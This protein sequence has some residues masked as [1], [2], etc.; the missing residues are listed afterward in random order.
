MSSEEAVQEVRRI[1]MNNSVEQVHDYLTTITRGIEESDERLKQIVGQSY[2]DL[3]AACDRVVGMERTC[4]KLLALQKQLQLEQPHQQAQKTT[5]SSSPLSTVGGDLLDYSHTPRRMVPT[6]HNEAS[7]RAVPPENSAFPTSTVQKESTVPDLNVLELELRRKLFFQHRCMAIEGLLGA[8]EVQKAAAVLQE[9]RETLRN[10]EN[11]VEQGL[12]LPTTTVDRQQQQQQQL[13]LC[14]SRLYNATG[15]LLRKDADDAALRAVAAAASPADAAGAKHRVRGNSSVD[16]RRSDEHMTDS[17]ESSVTVEHMAEAHAALGILSEVPAPPALLLLI[18]LVSRMIEGDLHLISAVESRRSLGRHATAGDDGARP[19]GVME[20]LRAVLQLPPCLLDSGEAG[21]LPNVTTRRS[22]GEGNKQDSRNNAVIALHAVQRAQQLFFHLVAYVASVAPRLCGPDGGGV[23]ATTVEG[24]NSGG[25][26]LTAE[27]EDEY[28]N[29]QRRRRTVEGLLTLRTRL[30]AQQQEQGEKQL[31]ETTDMTPMRLSGSFTRDALS[32]SLRAVTDDSVDSSLLHADTA[33]DLHGPNR[34]RART[35]YLREVMRHV[36][37]LQLLDPRPLRQ[38]KA[39][40]KYDVDSDC[41]GESNNKD[42]SKDRGGASTTVKYC[43]V[44]ER[45]LMVQELVSR[46][47]GCV[48]EAGLL[49]EP[50]CIGVQEHLARSEASGMQTRLGRNNE[51]LFDEAKW[52]AMVTSTTER[53]LVKA[54]GAALRKADRVCNSILERV[55][56]DAQEE[57]Q[58]PQSSQVED[59][60]RSRPRAP[61]QLTQE[62][63]C[64]SLCVSQRIT[65]LKRGSGNARRYSSPSVPPLKRPPPSVKDGTA[66]NAALARAVVQCVWSHTKPLADG[67]TFYGTM[68]PRAGGSSNSGST[69][70]ASAAPSAATFAANIFAAVLSGGDFSRASERTEEEMGEELLFADDDDEKVEDNNNSTPPPAAAE[71]ATTSAAPASPNPAYVDEGDDAADLSVLRHMLLRIFDAE[72]VQTT[73]QAAA[74]SLITAWITTVLRRVQELMRKREESQRQQLQQLQEDSVESCASMMVMFDRFSLLVEVL[75][76]AVETAQTMRGGGAE[77]SKEPTALLVREL[78]E[79]LVA[80]Y[81]PWVQLLRREWESGLSAAYREALTVVTVTTA[82]PSLASRRYTLEYAACWRLS[83][84][85]PEAQEPQRHRQQQQPIAYPVHLT[86]HVAEL[87][88]TLQHILYM[89]G[90][91]QRLHDTVLPILTRELLDGTAAAVLNVV[92]PFMSGAAAT[93][94]GD[95]SAGAGRG[96]GHTHRGGGADDDKEEALLQL[97]FDVRYIAGLFTQG[98]GASPPPIVS[99][100][101]AI[102]ERIDPVAWSLASPLLSRANERLLRATALSF[103]SWSAAAIADLGDNA[104]IDGGRVA[105]NAQPQFNGAIVAATERERFPLLPLT[106]TAPS[107]LTLTGATT[108]ARGGLGEV[109]PGSS[110]SSRPWSMNTTATAGKK[111]AVAAHSSSTASLLWGDSTKKGWMGSLW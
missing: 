108:A 89:V 97:Y 106:T 19:A 15:E 32:S 35:A 58:R 53:A 109:L 103:G 14:A 5:L 12:L 26:P 10:K 27:E 111:G 99:V 54:M 29:C 81:T 100:L 42:N 56:R 87:L 7:P 20:W 23:G 52:V 82:A 60:T 62:L 6:P 88:F 11:V 92:L 39:G 105:T 24:D 64:R 13:E 16:T 25:R 71:T 36:C 1:F 85:Q 61:P 57:Q 93:R 31:T 3:I 49:R 2:R 75:L 55:C 66:T 34:S 107:P 4:N 37:G 67:K 83:T 104:A 68:Y 72:H 33:A 51:A 76:Q 69:N 47:L 91:G 9:L 98:E 78:R 102:E 77:T 63:L 41:N 17:S 59:P 94:S 84:E 30:A 48:A 80:C 44:R 50:H 40:K 8:Q 43:D 101:R 65:A 45:L 110:T 28:A 90:V 79:T 86:P 95:S 96:V 21:K 74:H 38:A 70:N 46:L 73:A 18:D 22:I